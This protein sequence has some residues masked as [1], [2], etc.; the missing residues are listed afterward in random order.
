MEIF[1]ALTSRA[2]LAA[3]LEPDPEVG[4]G[5]CRVFADSGEV[6]ATIETA[7]E[8]LRKALFQEE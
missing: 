4:R 2:D 5:G 3:R 6:D 8:N 7:M 1:R